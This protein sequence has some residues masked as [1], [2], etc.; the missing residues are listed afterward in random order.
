MTFSCLLRLPLEGPNDV[1]QKGTLPRVCGDSDKFR[2]NGLDTFVLRG[3][4][5]VGRMTQLEMSHDDSGLCPGAG[6]EWDV[7]QPTDKLHFG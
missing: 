3:Q 6:A 5:D 1:A 7:S 2:R 4:S